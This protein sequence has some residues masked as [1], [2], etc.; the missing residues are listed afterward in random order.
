MEMIH[1]MDRGKHVDHACMMMD[2]MENPANMAK[3]QQNP[4][5][6]KLA[7]RLQQLLGEQ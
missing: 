3:N 1:I 7:A 2:I 6:Q 5:F 4:K